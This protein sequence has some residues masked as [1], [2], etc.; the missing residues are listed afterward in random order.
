[1]SQHDGDYQNVSIVYHAIGGYRN[2]SDVSQIPRFIVVPGIKTA[3]K[4]PVKL[5]YGYEKTLSR[6]IQS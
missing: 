1:L 3:E 5:Q 6:I 2:I 4:G